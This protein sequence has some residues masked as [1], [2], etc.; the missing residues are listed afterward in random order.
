MKAHKPSMKARRAAEWNRPHTGSLPMP[1][2]KRGMA[3]REAGKTRRTK[4]R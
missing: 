3:D 4:R 1:E 2:R